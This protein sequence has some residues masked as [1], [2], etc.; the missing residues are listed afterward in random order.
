MDDTRFKK[1][2]V[3][4]LE[5]GPADSM[6]FYAYPDE[7]SML[8]GTISS[9]NYNRGGLP[10]DTEEKEETQVSELT[11]DLCKLKAAGY[12]CEEVIQLKAFGLIK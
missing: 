10:K 12:S 6:D 5:N 4:G 2:V 9:L 1:Y 8:L 7:S 11:D 3:Y